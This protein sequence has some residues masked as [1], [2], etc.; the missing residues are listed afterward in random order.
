MRICSGQIL[1]PEELCPNH[2]K[3]KLPGYKDVEGCL[4]GIQQRPVRAAYESS[5]WQ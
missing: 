4:A 5:S 2:R 1:P 3:A